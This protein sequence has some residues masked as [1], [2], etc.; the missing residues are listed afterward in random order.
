MNK[1]HQ[2]PNRTTKRL[3]V[4]CILLLIVF[5]GCN[6]VSI[7][8]YFTDMESAKA[9]F[10]LGKTVVEVI[11]DT[12]NQEISV[13][14]DGTV[15]CYI[16]VFAEMER[17]DMTFSIS[18]EQGWDKTGDYYYYQSYVEPEKT[19]AFLKGVNFASDDEI[20]VYAECIQREGFSSAEEAF[21]L[22]GETTPEEN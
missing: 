1:A 19:V 15:D 8:A 7:K 12:E 16:R 9:S 10:S 6:V 14:N 11:E 2:K 3:A 17:S 18:P 5:I 13:Y 20:I 4:I 21:G 22:S